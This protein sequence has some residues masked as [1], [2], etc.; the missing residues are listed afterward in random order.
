MDD[1]RAAVYTLA[2][3][4]ETMGQ[5]VR[6][7]DDAATALALI[8]NERP[9]LVISDLAMPNMNGYEL[10]QRLREDPALVGLGACGFDRLWAGEQSAAGKGGGL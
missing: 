6:T 9:D 4:L 2:R 7:A 5:K 10:A 1:T 3:L 8:Q